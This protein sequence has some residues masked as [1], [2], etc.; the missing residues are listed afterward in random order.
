MLVLGIFV[1]GISPRVHNAVCIS[2]QTWDHRDAST[3][4]L[5]S[6]VHAGL[7]Q[8]NCLPHC[9]PYTMIKIQWPLETVSS[10][11]SEESFMAAGGC[12]HCHAVLLHAQQKHTQQKRESNPKPTGVPKPVNCNGKKLDT[13]QPVLA[14]QIFLDT[15]CNQYSKLCAAC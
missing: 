1:D 11:S 13:Q 15:A 8:C 6:M 3:V 14:Q 7:R 12:N 4:D 2:W 9:S 5:Q 10:P